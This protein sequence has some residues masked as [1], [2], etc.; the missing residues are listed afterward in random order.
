MRMR[1]EFLRVCD[2]R[3]EY[4]DVGFVFRTSVPARSLL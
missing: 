1:I 2:L 4:I 3:C